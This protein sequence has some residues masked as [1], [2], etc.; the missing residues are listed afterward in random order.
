[1]ELALGGVVFESNRL[2]LTLKVTLEMELENGISDRQIIVKRLVGTL[3]LRAV[4]SGYRFV[5]ETI[6]LIAK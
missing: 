6:Q 5:T 1:M 4:D 3:G 2:I